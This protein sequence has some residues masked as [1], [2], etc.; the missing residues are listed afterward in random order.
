MISAQKFK[1]GH[2]KKK[3]PMSEEQAILPDP[4]WLKS[5]KF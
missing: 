4:G 1:E 3:I 5:T 2:K